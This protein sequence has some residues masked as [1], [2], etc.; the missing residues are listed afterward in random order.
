MLEGTPRKVQLS[1]FSYIAK[2]RCDYFVTL[3]FTFKNVIVAVA[4]SSAV[5]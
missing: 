3:T 2:D 4:V 1:P 5:V